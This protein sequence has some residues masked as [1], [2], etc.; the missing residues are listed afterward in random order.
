MPETRKVGMTLPDYDFRALSPIDF[1]HLTRD[2]LNADLKLSLQGY[3]PG[4]DQG[5]DLRQ[6]A[7]DGTVTVVQCK[8]YLD[9]SWST[10]MRAVRKEAERGLG[11]G[12]SRYL[13]V[14][15]RALTPH[16]Q[17]EIVEALRPMG[18]TH[19]HVWGRESL[20]EALS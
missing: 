3:A 10:F 13:F 6:V 19:D 16:Q 5:I 15:S 9:S 14:T 2:V 7:A 11:L 1:E 18:V 20:N 8:H 12:A 17:D 4:P